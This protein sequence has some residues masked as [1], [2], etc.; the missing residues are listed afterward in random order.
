VKPN[1]NLAVQEI[2]RITELAQ[3][4]PEW[5]DLFAR[6]PGATTFQR[7]EWLI[8]WMEVFNPGEL[9]T[10]AVRQAGSL[11]GIA[12]LYIQQKGSERTLAPVG[13]AIS[14]YL[15]WQFDPA[16]SSS[17]LACLLQ[18]IRDRNSVWNIF[19]LT[20]IP[21]H[22]SLLSLTSMAEWDMESKF[23]D[24]C[25]VLQLPA[26]LEELQHVIPRP[27]L[28]SLKS[29]R[30]KIQLLGEV[31]VEVAS[32][33]NLDDLLATLFRL[34]RTRW[35]QFGMTGVLAGPDVQRFHQRAAPALLE[36]GVL[37]LYALRLH[38]R[39]LAALYALFEKD[40]VYCYLQGFDP[41]F[42]E[43]SPG[44]QILAAVIEDAVRHHKRS[45]DF[46]RGREAYKYDWGAR[47]VPTYRLRARE[48]LPLKD[49]SVQ[50]A[51]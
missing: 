49:V 36:K 42:A 22:S 20:D 32:R 14:D 7:P 45:I 4:A 34:H 16:V 50:I 33:E 28:R 43:F 1:C 15:D 13:A 38:D 51:A 19:D 48:R 30:K 21:G 23:H 35:S 37:R 24:A 9:W 47:D 40:V 26:T 41:E 5:D 3:L 18:H 17:V 25:P 31:R 12:P 6:C 44:A 11:V 39:V 29:A 8:S 2:T 27:R 10:L 46:L